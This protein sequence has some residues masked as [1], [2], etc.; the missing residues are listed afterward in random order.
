[1][2]TKITYFLV[3]IIAS[4]M[5]NAPIG[6]AATVTAT[7]DITNANGTYGV[8][9][10]LFFEVSFAGGTV[11]ITKDVSRIKLNLNRLNDDAFAFA[12]TTTNAPAGAVL[13]E[14]KI[15]QGDFTTDLNLAS[16]VPITNVSGYDGGLVDN[17]AAKAIAVATPLKI[18]S[19]SATPS[20][21]TRKV[22]DKVTITFGLD[23]KVSL[24]PT[25][26]ATS[27]TFSLQ[28][29]TGGTGTSVTKD[30]SGPITEI[31]FE[32]TVAD[33]HQS[34]DLDYVSSTAFNWNGGTVDGLVGSLTLP[35]PGTAPGTNTPGSLGGNASLVIDGILPVLTLTPPALLQRS[36][37]LV[38]TVAAT[39]PVK[40]L[41]FSDFTS[42]P[43]GCDISV[44]G[45]PAVLRSSWNVNVTPKSTLTL[46]SNTKAGDTVL[47]TS[48]D[49]NLAAGDPVVINGKNYVV[50][51][52]DTGA[53]PA[54]LKLTSGIEALVSSTSIFSNTNSK[55]TLAI[56]SGAATDGSGNVTASVNAT[57]EVVYDPVPPFIKS[58]TKGEEKASTASF[59]ITFSEDVVNVP[60]SDKFTVSNGT[61]TSITGSSPTFTVNIKRTRPMEATTVRVNANA[62]QDAAGNGNLVSATETSTPPANALSVKSV[63]AANGKYKLGAQI[64][65]AVELFLPVTVAGSGATL[66]LGIGEHP[67][68]ASYVS[69]TT[70]TDKTTLLFRYTVQEG[71]EAAKLNYTSDPFVRG[72]LS[73]D[74][75]TDLTI[76]FPDPAAT[77]PVTGTLAQTSD[78]KVDGK[79]PTFLLTSTSTNKLDDLNKLTLTASED[80][81]GLE[82]ANLVATNTEPTTR[83]LSKKDDSKKVYTISIAPLAQCKLA[84]NAFFRSTSVSLKSSSVAIPLAAGAPIRIGTEIYLVKTS[85]TIAANDKTTVT[86]TSG[87]TANLGTGDPVLTM[88]VIMNVGLAAGA[89]S[90][91]AGNPSAVLN[92]VAITYDP[93]PP[94]CTVTGVGIQDGKA[95]FFVEFSEDV[96][97]LDPEKLTLVNNKKVTVT[98]KNNNRAFD[99]TIEPNTVGA[100]V[101]LTV[102]AGA[103]Q[104]LA[105][106]NNLISN[107]ATVTPPAPVL[108][109]DQSKPYEKTAPVT[110]AI[111]SSDAITGLDKDDFILTN[112]TFVEL[113]GTGKSY[114]LQVEPQST[115]TLGAIARAQ[116]KTVFLKI[117]S[118]TLTLKE[119]TS[120]S[121]K[122]TTT[123]SIT[124]AEETPIDANGIETSITESL[125]EDLPEKT[126]LWR[127]SGEPISVSIKADAVV[128]DADLGNAATATVTKI[129]DFTPPAVAEWDVTGSTPSNRAFY[130]TF[131]EPVAD[132]PVSA[133]TLVGGKIGQ[134]VKPTD[135]FPLR[136]T[137]TVITE[138][139]ETSSLSVVAGSIADLAGNSI[140]ASG[141]Y[142]FPKPAIVPQVTVTKVTARNVN[143]SYGAGLRLRIQ[144]RFSEIVNV[145]GVP[146][147]QLALGSG[148]LATYSDGSG[149]TDLLFDYVVT[150]GD[151]SSDLDYGSSTA[152]V[153]PTTATIRD[154]DGNAA[155]LTLPN[156][157]T[158]GSLSANANLVI[159]AGV[160]TNPAKPEVDG[161]ASSGGCGAGSGIALALGASWLGLSRLRRRRAA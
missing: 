15:R 72:T 36:A 30:L 124:L 73:F 117:P 70:E 45:D 149:S 99:V 11:G 1:M 97:S 110:F 71:D 145:V 106:N 140:A 51:A 122:S 22:G 63:S 23:R 125:T 90:D 105:K 132:V 156:P 98:S 20:A 32:Y 74:G 121:L 84:E 27:V 88:P 58:L 33:G 10:K 131:N 128:N 79:I 129:Y 138:G 14:Y 114:S 40:G 123:T 154:V 60:T 101:E 96:F 34:S 109:I 161:A 112:C 31:P 115:I 76:A 108:T 127:T 55:I 113:K 69:A 135:Q 77:P 52:K 61:V 48:A 35:A 143:G 103:A 85:T 119:G 78:V 111:T 18:A 41:I 146:T 38:F 86:L 130:L 43:L 107:K 95:L 142:S 24:A 12:T 9:D 100:K 26:P 2:F 91:D 8:D 68:Q 81:T 87:L 147:L 54:T 65:L 126:Q 150:A 116:A 46:A 53:A 47:T 152:L 50:A 66:A 157:G 3:A 19:I 89:A 7:V 102:N 17:V 25:S 42:T 137:V 80:V 39:K 16:P 75:R 118:G 104:D 159:D 67:R 28:L 141:P 21:G 5:L 4:W 37:P 139:S 6:F 133:L 153:L 158:P 82:T 83:S 151:K 136:W 120:L 64:D 29:A 13:F 57:E 144:V 59:T 44:S 92:P 62:F 93:L 49:P 94:T 56:S 155:R 148:K 160:N 134:V